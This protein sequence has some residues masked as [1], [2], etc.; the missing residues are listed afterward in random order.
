MKNAAH[1]PQNL[2]DD[3]SIETSLPQ[4]ETP[5]EPLEFLSRSWSLSAN[6]VSKAIAQ[7]QKQCT[8]EKIPNVIPQTVITTQLSVKVM[9][10]ISGRRHGA[11]GRWFHHK[12]AGN[13][14]MKKKDK[15]QIENAHS[16]YSM[17]R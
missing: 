4:P 5:S 17:L 12:D 7:K 15:A 2:D 16:H 10:P 13:M 1:W 6:E 11:I 3:P 8:F 9:N 14:S